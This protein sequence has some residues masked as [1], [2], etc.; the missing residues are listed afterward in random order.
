MLA[1]AAFATAAIPRHF[2]RRAGLRF[3]FGDFAIDLERRELRR[4]GEL[5]A[6][7]PQVFDLLVYLIGHRDRVISKDDLLRDV[8]GGRIVSDSTLTSRIY[9]ARRAIGD[10][11][12]AQGLIRTIAR[13]GVRF[14][15]T[16]TADGDAEFAPAAPADLTAA[17]VAQQIRFCTAPDGV[18]IAYASAGEGP[19]LVKA[20]NWL[21]HLEYDWQSPIWSPL[22]RELATGRR[23]VRYDGRGNGLSDWDVRDLSFEAQVRDLE[24]VVA[25]ARL[26]RFALFGMSQGCAVSIAYAARHPERVSRLILYGGYARGRRRR[27]SQADI[28]QA[29]AMVTLIRQ[30]WGQENPVF[31]QIFTSLVLPD[32][33]AEQMQWFNDLQRNTTSP[34]NAAR[35][36]EAFDDIDVSDL[37]P[38]VKVPTLVLHRRRDDMVPFDEGRLLAAAIPGARFAALEGRN[39]LL[40][41]GEPAWLRFLAEVNQFLAG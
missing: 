10:T 38:Q 20:A 40:L 17:D 36:R 27:G 39:H 3:Q 31:R 5:V 15:G 37:L 12:S 33:T 32:G 30:G 22:F 14:V 25:A 21:N 2:S 8:W 28:D 29:E 35:L 4:G 9:A 16:V 23:L 1:A 19:P 18:R 24:S 7:E 41:Q 34:D 26:Q 6:V 13:K 11:G